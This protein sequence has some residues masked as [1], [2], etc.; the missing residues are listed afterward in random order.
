MNSP[1]SLV[2]IHPVLRKLL[3]VFCFVLSM[4]YFSGI[5]LV[6]YT[7]G[8]TIQ[9]V[10]DN[11][12][13]NEE[14]EEATEMKFKKSTHEMLSIIHTHVI[15]LSIVFLFVGL[16]IVG[17]D[18]PLWLKSLLAF[19]PFLSIMVTF[20]GIYLMWNGIEWLS[21]LI[22]I[23]GLLMNSCFAISMVIVLYTLIFKKSN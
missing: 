22:Y 13:G 19:E 8:G 10:Q 14:D 11:Y 16:L 4:G 7:T 15:S 1:Y 2:G 18:I 9:G 23:S 12:L 21:T 17:C 20:G 3:V 5:C 6:S